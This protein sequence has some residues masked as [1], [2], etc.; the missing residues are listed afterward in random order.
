MANG[1]STFSV[2]GSDVTIKGD[3]SASVDLHIDGTI[4][5][6][7]EIIAPDILFAPGARV[8]GNLRYT[9]NK[10]LV[11]AEGVV[12]GTLTRIQPQPEPLFS[13]G[14]LQSHAMWFFAALLAGIPFITLF[15]MSTAMAS[16][17]ARKA[18]LKC[19]LVGL[20][21]SVALPMLGLMA[22][23]SLIGVP[24]GILLLAGWGI[25]V[26]LSRIITGLVIGTMLLRSVSTSAGRVLLTLALG[27]LIIYLIIL[28]PAI[29]M[30]VQM[31]VM[32][33]GMGAL[34]LAL[35]EKRR[36]I[37]QVPQSLKTLEQLRHGKYKPAE[38]EP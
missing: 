19:L 24:L 32:W 38:E 36:L 33:L 4:E 18:P 26:Y 31:S 21:A 11:P 34:I 14:R 22:V 13:A 7:L 2:I 27:L 12:G 1:N 16:Q 5:G 3:V 25:M 8:A 23:S 15:P 17:L 29:S 20:A 9:A 30:P 37:I 28:I 35:L 6:D 10:E